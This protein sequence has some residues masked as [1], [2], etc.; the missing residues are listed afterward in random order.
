M[1]DTKSRANW[2]VLMN[3]NFLPSDIVISPS[4]LV[5]KERKT[6]RSELILIKSRRLFKKAF[7]RGR[8]ERRGEA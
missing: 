1:G 6:A 7:Q 5:W 4:T 2:S 3:S 8:N